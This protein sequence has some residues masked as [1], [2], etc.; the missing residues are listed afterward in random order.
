MAFNSVIAGL[1]VFGIFLL[2]LILERGLLLPTKKGLRVLMY[3]RISSE[4]DSKNL[5]DDLWVTQSSFRRQLEWILS[6]GLLPIRLSE[7][8]SSLASSNPVFPQGRVLITFDDGYRD[9]LEWALPVLKALGIPAVIFLVP[10]FIEEANRGDEPG[11]YLNRA[12][13]D[14]LKESGLIEFAIHSYEHVNYRDLAISSPE[15]LESDVVKAHEYLKQQGIPY[16]PALAYPYGA[17]PKNDQSA[18]ERML[19]ILREKG[20]RLAF[21]IGNRVNEG[22]MNAPLL[23]ER[24]DI[25]GS[26]SFQVFKIKVKKGRAKVFA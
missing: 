3:H 6:Q 22:A 23:V 26:D 19:L 5:P 16:V 17:I 8:E 20:I 13:L 10:A 7:L 25:K 1:F 15:K 11:K 4:S 14:S 9:N 2:Y 21:R 24:I 18:L 12:D